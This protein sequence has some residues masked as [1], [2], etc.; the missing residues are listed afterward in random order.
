MWIIGFLFH[1]MAFGLLSVFLPLYITGSLGG[2]LIDIGIMAALANF[3]GVPF[4]FFWGY[5][6]DKTRR[7]RIYIL[8]SFSAMTVL[9]FLFSLTNI[10]VILI[11]VY[12]VIAVFHVAHEAPKNVLISE[13]YSQNEWKKGFASYEAL[14]ELGW[15]SG[16]ILGFVLFGYGFNGTTL[17]LL[18]S[19]LNLIAFVTALLFVKD[20]IL[21]FE[22]RLVGIERTLSFAHKGISLASQAL[23]GLQIKENLR[24]ENLS[25]FCAGLLLFSL[26]ASMLFTPLPVFFSTN[27]GI[28][29]NLVFGIFALNTTGSFLGYVLAGKMAQKLDGRTVI[30]RANLVRGILPWIFLSTVIWFSV[31]TLTLSVIALIIMGMTYGFFLIS[32]LSL[33]M[34]LIPEGKAGLFNALVGL[35]GASGCYIGSYMAEN[36]GFPI[37][38]IIVSIG[39]FLSFIAFKTFAK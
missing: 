18:C 15:L 27:L 9:L 2:S 16:L 17:I 10:L 1:E 22:R 28:P 36:Y 21:I 37:L 29:R 23:D 38:F 14:T 35:G 30:K 32:I 3:V 24:R 25:I 6:C 5:L 19:A 31:F 20:P 4:S 39:F 8:L 33:S 26:T 13:S 12:S 7:Y 11:A 34:E